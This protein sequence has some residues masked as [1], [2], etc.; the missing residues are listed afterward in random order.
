LARII[1]GFVVFLCI[2]VSAS[3][4]ILAIIARKRE[5]EREREKERERERERERGKEKKREEDWSSIIRRE[6]KEHARTWE[7]SAFPARMFR[8][9]SSSYPRLKER[10]GGKKKKEKGECKGKRRRSGRPL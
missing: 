8:A 10:K 4:F 6:E 2:L 5:R 7:R 9:D 1:A 3:A